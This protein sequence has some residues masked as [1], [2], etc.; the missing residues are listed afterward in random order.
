MP[1]PGKAGLSTLVYS[2]KG[3]VGLSAHSEPSRGA[4]PAKGT[5]IGTY[6][7]QAIALHGRAASAHTKCNLN[8]EGSALRSRWEAGRGPGRPSIGW[9]G[10][11]GVQVLPTC[12]DGVNQSDLKGGEG[13]GMAEHWGDMWRLVCSQV[14]RD[15]SR[16]LFDR[17]K[18]GYT[19]LNDG[20]DERI[21]LPGPGWAL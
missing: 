5:V 19:D 1:G 16:G 15:R 18:I 11:L 3:S 7:H 12:V 20:I 14:R 21:F 17:Y 6:I 8:N 10:E 9:Q 4:A 2:I 13:G